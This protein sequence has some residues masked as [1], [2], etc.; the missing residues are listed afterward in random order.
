MLLRD[1]YGSGRKISPTTASAF[2]GDLI[3]SGERPEQGPYLA[4]SNN[5]P[6]VFLGNRPRSS[7]LASQ[8]RSLHRSSFDEVRSSTSIMRFNNEGAASINCLRAARN[9]G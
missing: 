1:N 5:A 6:T 9:F 8:R 3:Q 2:E 4:W 7:Q